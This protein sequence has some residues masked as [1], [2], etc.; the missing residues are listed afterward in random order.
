LVAKPSTQAWAGYFGPNKY[1]FGSSTFGVDSSNNSEEF[2]FWL[3][4]VATFA[5]PLFFLIL[6]GVVY[7]L[8]TFVAIERETSMAELMAAQGVSIAPRILSTFLSF[9]SLYF[10]GF[11]FSSIIMTQVLVCIFSDKTLRIFISS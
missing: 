1:D 4:I 5:A 8:A 10:P 11:L 3:A 7:H 6:I 9:F 2:A